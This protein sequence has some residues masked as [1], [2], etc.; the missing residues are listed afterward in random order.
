MNVRHWGVLN[1]GNLALR[2]HIYKCIPSA[3]VD[4]KQFNGT[5]IFDPIKVC[6]TL[7]DPLDYD[8]S[9]YEVLSVVIRY[10][11]SYSIVDDTKILLCFAL[12]VDISVDIIIGIPFIHELSMEL[13]LIL[14]RK[15]LAHEMK[16][17]FP[18]K[19]KETVLT[20][21]DS[22]PDTTVVDSVRSVSEITNPTGTLGTS[23]VMSDPLR[24]FL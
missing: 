9:K 13:W 20:T 10:H 1:T 24:L 23:S 3:M 19:Y 14:T 2:L 5:N 4:F 16:T 7:L 15:F 6:G 8:S 17:S 12:C 11:I 21:F 22:V 18:V